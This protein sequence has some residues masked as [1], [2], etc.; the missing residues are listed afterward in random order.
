MTYKPYLITLP[1]LA[2]KSGVLSFLDEGGDLPI[3]VKRVYWIYNVDE[4]AVR[5]NHAHVNADRVIACLSGSVTVSM[6]D[7][8]GKAYSFVL[9]DPSKALYFPRLHWV[10]LTFTK[11]AILIALSSCVFENDEIVSDYDQFKKLPVNEFS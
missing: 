4:A 9:D 8:Q 7:V 1:K 11:G 6:E 3:Q 5:G 2:G 10:R